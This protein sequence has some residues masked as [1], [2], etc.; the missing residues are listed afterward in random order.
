MKQIANQIQVQTQAVSKK[1]LLEK[2]AKAEIEF[3]LIRPLINY[4]YNI[5]RAD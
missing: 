2:I 1:T 4:G 3:D 5:N